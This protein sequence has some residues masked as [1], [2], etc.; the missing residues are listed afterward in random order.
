MG[1]MVLG[2][3]AGQ[4]A[5]TDHTILVILSCPLLPALNGTDSYQ[6]PCLL[7]AQGTGSRAQQKAAELP[8][9]TGL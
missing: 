9:N 6:W 7:K 2:P 1:V 3:C 5:L 4:A 8:I